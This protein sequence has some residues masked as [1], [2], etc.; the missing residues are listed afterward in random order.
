M[1]LHGDHLIRALIGDPELQK[2]LAKYMVV[3]CFRNTFLRDLH[4][5][6]TPSLADGD[7]SDVFVTSP[8]GEIPW[9]RYLTT[10]QIAMDFSR[11][12]RETQEVEPPRNA[13]EER[14]ASSCLNQLY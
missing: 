5:G 12:T 4:S 1:G 3:R 14:K 6:I 10:T 9:R 13:F 8:Y 2:R 11:Q 7:Y